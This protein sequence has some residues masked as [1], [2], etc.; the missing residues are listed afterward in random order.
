MLI[1]STIQTHFLHRGNFSKKNKQQEIHHL[2]AKELQNI[3]IFQCIVN[4]RF[5]ECGYA[6]RIIH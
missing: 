2:P 4:T 5:V 6:Y 1:L 3:S